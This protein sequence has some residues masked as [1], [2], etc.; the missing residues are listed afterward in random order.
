MNV[1]VKNVARKEE[2]VMMSDEF[3]RTIREKCKHY[4][5]NL[6]SDSLCKNGRGWCMPWGRCLFFENKEELCIANLNRQ[7]ERRRK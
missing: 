2:G 7:E 5:E 4:D 3:K 6:D 1:Y